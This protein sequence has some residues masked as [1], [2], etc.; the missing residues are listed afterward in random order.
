MRLRLPFLLLCSLLLVAAAR[1][2]RRW[3]LRAS[4][5]CDDVARSSATPITKAELRL[6]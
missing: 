6:H 4:V 3:Q 5:P 1:R 2:V